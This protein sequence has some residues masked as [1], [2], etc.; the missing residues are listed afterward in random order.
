MNQ[1]DAFFLLLSS[2]L[3][4]LIFLITLHASFAAIPYGITIGDTNFTCGANDSICP[5]DYVNCEACTDDTTGDTG[6]VADDPDCC[7]DN[8]CGWSCTDAGVV[9]GDSTN[10]YSKDETDSE[11]DSVD[12]GGEEDCNGS[13]CTTEEVIDDENNPACVDTYY[14]GT[15]TLGYDYTYNCADDGVLY[16]PYTYTSNLCQHDISCHDTEGDGDDEVCD[17][18]NWHDPDESETYCDAA[19]GTWTTGS[20]T[21]DTFNDDYDGDLTNGYCDGDDGYYVTGAVLAE[22]YRGSTSCEAAEDVT[23]S[24]KDMSD[25]TIVY[26]S[27][28][29]E[30]SSSWSYETF[31]CQSGNEVG[32]YTVTLAP[33]EY[34]LVAEKDEFNTVTRSI[35]LSTMTDDETLDSFWIYYSA[36][37][38]SDCTKNDRICYAECEGV[39][40]CTFP[41]YEGTSVATYCDG[42]RKGYRYTLTEVTDETDNSV[43][44]Y[45]VSCCNNEPESYTR[46]Y[47]T[48][49]DVVTNCVENIIS[50]ER[51]VLVNG[52]L[53]TLHFVLFSDPKYE[54][55]G[56]EEYED[57]RCDVYGDAFC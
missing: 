7:E 8:A 45:E 24:I 16:H 49:E 14:N 17:E 46:D 38:Q 31:T 51:T 5:S 6:A 41:S 50:R 3:L 20:S 30:Y 23:I 55:E 47:F 43:E 39:N 29:T 9:C 54:K 12:N 35:D 53:L 15:D 19:G 32:T 36:D 21:S 56:C 48:A 42:L 52:E 10:E 33:G 44:G 57:F 11:G 26:D 2:P 28:T 40:D 4:I 1:R 25:T 37:C 13:G 34:Y 22:T 18:G 27:D